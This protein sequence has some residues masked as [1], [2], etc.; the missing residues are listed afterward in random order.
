M[1]QFPLTI[2]CTAILSVIYAEEPN[3]TSQELPANIVFEEQFPEVTSKVSEETSATFE[4]SDEELEQEL[5]SLEKEL[6]NENSE[7][8]ATETPA[9]APETQVATEAVTPQEVIEPRPEVALITKSDNEIIDEE[10][11][12]IAVDNTQQPPSDSSQG[13]QTVASAEEEVA[14]ASFP[15]DEVAVNAEPETRVAEE[16]VIAHREVLQSTPAAIAEAPKGE[17]KARKLRSN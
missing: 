10:V 14:D 16:K 13:G 2:L 8:L 1:K 7:V 5:L 15:S 3:A 9:Q 6:E 12:T 11:Q 4:I 17:K